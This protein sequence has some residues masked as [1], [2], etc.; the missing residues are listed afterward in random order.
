MSARPASA[1]EIRVLHRDDWFLVLEKPSGI[2]TTSPDGAP[3]LTSLAQALDPGAPR[4]HP[5]SRLDAEV[6]GVVIFAR[7]REATQHLLAAREH[8]AYARV[9]V[10]L[11][12]AAPAPPAGDWRG[13]IGL[14]ARDPRKRVV[15]EGGRQAEAARPAHTRYRV[16]AQ[17]ERA[18]LLRLEP[19][20]GR[21]HQLRVH[22]ARAGVPLLGDRHY[23]GAQRVVLGDGRVLSVRRTMLHCMRVSVPAPGGVGVLVFEAEP[24]E[25]MLAVWRG[26]GGEDFAAALAE[27]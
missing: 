20:T 25:E 10:A 1:P 19:Q 2:A 21:T 4:L 8:G 23:G 7:T 11:S 14:D 12:A 3:A 16:V 6:S 18:A 24:P 13:A 5:S 17:R 15:V 9:Y 22:A 26:V 27:R